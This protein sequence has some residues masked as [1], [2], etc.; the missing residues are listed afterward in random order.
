[1]EKEKSILEKNDL[2]G[3]AVKF[4][5]DDTRYKV[6]HYDGEGDRYLIMPSEEHMVTKNSQRWVKRE[7]FELF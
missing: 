2:L 5:E 3:A 4:G 7:Q 1:M 6:V